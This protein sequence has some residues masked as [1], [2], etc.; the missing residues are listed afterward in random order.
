MF[1]YIFIYEHVIERETERFDE[2]KK[3]QRKSKVNW[4]KD[5]ESFCLFGLGNLRRENRCNQTQQNKPNHLTA[6]YQCSAVLM[7]IR[8]QIKVRAVHC[9][10]I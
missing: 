6:I 10:A 7:L 9:I 1:V 5:R 4:E 2:T 8:L 3:I